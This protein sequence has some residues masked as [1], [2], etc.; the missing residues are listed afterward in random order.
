MKN[1]NISREV[2]KK[3]KNQ[4]HSMDRLPN[5]YNNTKTANSSQG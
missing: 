5:F 2:S 4:V 3:K 1:T